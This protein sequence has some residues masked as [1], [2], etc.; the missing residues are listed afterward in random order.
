MR[1]LVPFHA[2]EIDKTMQ[3]LND[4]ACEGLCVETWGSFFVKLKEGESAD[5]IYQIDIDD[6]TGDPNYQ[7]KLELEK[8]DWQYVQ[9]IGTT[10]H[11]IY[12]TRNQSARLVWNGEYIEKYRKKQRVDLFWGVVAAIVCV[13]IYLWLAVFRN[14]DYLMLSLVESRWDLA[15][16]T[17]LVLYTMFVWILETA[18]TVRLERRLAEG[19]RLAE[20][21]DDNYQRDMRMRP[22]VLNGLGKILMIIT[23][24]GW[25]VFSL[26]LEDEGH[27]FDDSQPVLPCVDL[28]N[29]E[30]EGFEITEITW[31]DNPDVNFGNRIL[32]KTGLLTEYFCEVHQYGTDVAG[33]DVQ[34]S[35]Q[36]YKL[37]PDSI[38][39]AVLEQLIDR[40]TSYMYEHQWLEEDKKL[41]EDYWTITE[42]EHAAFESVVVADAANG[43]GPLMIFARVEDVIIYLRYYG[44]LPAG[45]FVEELTRL[46]P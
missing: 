37:R 33:E 32:E 46:Y 35:G 7:R 30:A 18:G 4:L 24:L 39:N 13:I 40:S 44:N 36:Y 26:G 17:V 20:R 12:R 11:H 5:W 14:W 43:D 45:S 23:T 25:S 22:K 6:S 16:I 2:N 29:L 3:W 27:N 8:Q 31:V 41:P 34:I 1:K 19:N 21:R 9:T 10:R 42:S 28:R 38:T 15:V